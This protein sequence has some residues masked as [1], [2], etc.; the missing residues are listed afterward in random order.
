MR[1]HFGGGLNEQQSPQLNE[2]AAGS[3][4]FE[5]SKDLFRLMPRKPFD[6][7]GT[8]TNAGNIR[9][10]IQLVKRDDSTTTLVQSGA[11]VYKWD[12]GTTWSSVGSANA[13]SQLRDSYW[14]LNDWQIVTDL[15]KLTPVS[16]WDGTTFGTI[17]TGLGVGLYAKYG[18]THQGRSWLFNVTTATDTPHLMVA[19][20]FENAQSYDTTKR[21]NGNLTSA[22]FTTGNEAFYMLTP[23]LR[24]IN[25]ACVFQKDLIIST[26]GGRLYRLTGTSSLDY[27]WSEFYVASNAI[28]DESFANI[29]NDIMYMRKGGNIE[30]VKAVISYGDVTAQ[31]MSRWIPTTV[32]DLTGAIIIYDQSN[33]KVFVFVTGKVLVFFKDVF[34]A[35]ALMDETGQRA[36]LSPWSVYTTQFGSQFNTSAAKYMRIPG[37][38]QYSVFFGDSSGNVFDMNGVG[39]SAGAKYLSLTGAAGTNARAPDS[40]A[41]DVPGDLQIIFYGALN[42]WTPAANTSLIAKYDTTG[43][44]QAYLLLLL[45]SG[46]LD[47]ITSANG[48]ALATQSISGVLPF[49]D[50]TGYWIKVAIDV[51]DGL[52]NNVVTFYS[53]SDPPTTAPGS[54][55]WT[56]LATR[57][58]A[59]TTSI[60]NSSAGLEIGSR[61][62]GTLANMAGKVY[63]AQV[64]NGTNLVADFNANNANVGAATCVAVTGET[65][66]LNGAASI[67]ASAALSGSGD[68]GLKTIQLR[69]KTRT[70]DKKDSIDFM[71]HVTRGSVQYRRSVQCNFSIDF[72]WSDEYSTSTVT[73]ALK[74]STGLGGAFFGGTFYF[75]GTNYFG[76]SSYL[77]KISHQN[78]SAVGKAGGCRLTFYS[79][80]AVQYG[81]DNVEL[82]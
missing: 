36:A 62:G 68:A 15:Q 3:Y 44:Q 6:L 52:G 19:S 65:Y 60:F 72:D 11:T 20:A 43:N 57:T 38:T 13:T 8:S 75:G 37:T 41:L 9:G 39:T 7:K 59:G 49:L 24:P 33:Q 48:A 26:T 12:G 45:T 73:L 32:K 1:F 5:L 50:G 28:G 35:G 18:L 74:G 78:F 10:F 77:D 66:T 30:S 40:A 67:A 76:G 14:S 17:S 51:D 54:V 79:D 71:G 70:V 64:Y 46:Q 47:F 2:A 55:A 56:L 61:D 82:V 4:N 80:T 53:S 21:V 16:Y 42:D 81:V 23:D 25:G 29:G 22:S 31:D 27:A 63:R 69:R 34:Y 58:N